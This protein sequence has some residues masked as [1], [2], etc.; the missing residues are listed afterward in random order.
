M[1]NKCNYNRILKCQVACIVCLSS[2]LLLL[3]LTL[4]LSIFTQ[5]LWLQT[6]KLFYLTS[7]HILLTVVDVIIISFWHCF[8]HVF[9]LPLLSHVSVSFG[10]SCTH[11]FYLSRSKITLYAAK[12]T[13]YMSPLLWASPFSDYFFW[14]ASSIQYSIQITSPLGHRAHFCIKLFWEIVDKVQACL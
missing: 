11:T 14:F 8:H 3:H 7:Q 4:I 10:A 9:L 12:K 1:W 13:R 6:G 5:H 2:I